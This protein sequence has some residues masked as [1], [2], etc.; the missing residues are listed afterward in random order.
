MTSLPIDQLI[1]TQRGL[2]SREIFVSPE[3]H[4][5]ELERVFSR[6]WLF[7]GHES[8]IPKPGDYFVSR[9]G[10]ESVILCRDAQSKVHV[11]LN[12]CRHRGMKVCRYEQGNTSLFVC[13]YHSWS[14]ATDGKLQGVPLFRR[15]L[16]RHA[17]PLAMV[18]DRDPKLQ[19]YKSTVW[20][21]W[22]PEAPDLM[23]YLGDAVDHLDQVLDCRDGRPGGSEVIGVQKWILPTNWKFAAENF[24]G[25]TYH[26]PSHRSVDMIGIGPRRNEANGAT[27]NMPRAS[28]SGSA[29]ARPRHAQRAYAGT[30]RLPAGLRAISGSR[31]IFSP[32]PFTNANAASAKRRDFCRSPATCFPTRPGTAASRA[33]CA[34]GIRTARPKPRPGASSWS[35]PT[36]PP[37]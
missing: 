9:M 36:R 37:R 29:S 8:Q 23:T 28:M 7:V 6:A 16:R 25:D 1:D 32:L 24:L 3:F 13:P 17:G 14:Y 11:F 34:S 31:G 10:D 12:S 26:N 2:I 27:T 18:A 5:Q 20:A 15:A 35:T 19:I 4:K 30:I 22:D 33:P 21:S